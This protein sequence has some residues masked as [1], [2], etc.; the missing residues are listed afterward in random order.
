M[1]PTK[2]SQNKSKNKNKLEDISDLY[3]RLTQIGLAPVCGEGYKYIKW[4]DLRA[5]LKELKI[6]E[7]FH[8]YFGIQTCCIDGPYAW[9]VEDVLER[10]F[11]NKR[12]GTQSAGGWD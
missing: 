10:I 2:H 1:K 11:S 3:P 12:V 7:V 5:K 8:E 9:D 4:E 6:E